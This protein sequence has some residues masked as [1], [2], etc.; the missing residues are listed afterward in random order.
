MGVNRLSAILLTLAL[1]LAGGAVPAVAAGENTLDGITVLDG[2]LSPAFTG[3]V[4]NY[5]SA[6]VNEITTA[7]ISAI[8][9]DPA[10]TMTIGGTAADSNVP[11]TVNL[12]PGDNRV[13]IVVT[14]T[15]GAQ[16]I[17]TVTVK[18]NAT[19]SEQLDVLNPG[20]MGNLIQNPGFEG[21]TIGISDPNKLWTGAP[22]N[23]NSSVTYGNY[24]AVGSYHAVKGGAAQN[25]YYG[26]PSYNASS[27]VTPVQY[28]RS[29]EWAMRV[30]GRQKWNDYTTGVSGS[31]SAGQIITTGI[32]PGKKYVYSVW[33]K[34]EQGAWG[35]IEITPYNGGTRLTPFLNETLSDKRDGTDSDAYAADTWYNFKGVVTMPANANAVRVVMMR[36]A[37]VPAGTPANQCFNAPIYDDFL[38]APADYVHVEPSDLTVNALTF[39]GGTLS[40]AFADGTTDYNLSL[41]YTEG[42][43]NLS[44]L[45]AFPDDLAAIEVNSTD[46]GTDGTPF[47]LRMPTGQTVLTITVIGKDTSRKTYTVTAFRDTPPMQAEDG[48]FYTIFKEDPVTTS[49][50]T[51]VVSALRSN[52]RA[53]TGAYSLKVDPTNANWNNSF[54]IEFPSALNLEP[55]RGYAA[56]QL[57]LYMTAPFHAQDAMQVNF[58]SGGASLGANDPAYISY[59]NASPASANLVDKNLTGAWQTIEVPLTAFDTLP[60]GTAVEDANKPNWSDIRKFRFYFNTANKGGL[61]SATGSQADVDAFVLYLDDIVIVD[62]RP[63]VT[64]TAGG[65]AVTEN[66]SVPAGSNALTLEFSAA[67]QPSTVNADF[68]ALRKN[69]VIMDNLLIGMTGNTALIQLPEQIEMYVPYTLEINSVSQTG[70]FNISKTLNFMGAP[71]APGIRSVTYRIDGVSAPLAP[72]DMTIEVTAANNTA[73]AV[74]AVILAGHFGADNKLK[75]FTVSPVTLPANNTNYQVPAAALR[76][77]AVSAGDYVGVTMWD[78]M[79]TITPMSGLYKLG[80]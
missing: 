9:T 23:A 1:L 4:A 49:S 56:V 67:M 20:P 45:P 3:D 6:F 69:G 79:D 66:G 29:G 40:P 5:T 61:N 13:D 42:I 57:K 60:N 46:I 51:N 73:S 18:R 43:T 8:K 72:G 19:P 10:A 12:T 50:I 35:P 14:P 63:N 47:E 52:E 59:F 21:F 48:E 37:N 30:G 76:I 33:V 62:K 78:S 25:W 24:E 71:S 7:Q 31:A 26:P 2:T 38:F 39:S 70:G 36:G 68:I 55:V 65:A 74:S 80:R 77:G 41:A 44:V 27:Q 11:V 53:A 32:V 17:Y 28:H 75:G 15:A 58:I 64:V 16:K 54:I 22:W 34:L